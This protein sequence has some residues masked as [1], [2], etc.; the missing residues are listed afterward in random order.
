[1]DTFSYS[2]TYGSSAKTKCRVLSTNFGDGYRQRAADGI[3]AA[4]VSWSLSFQHLDSEDVEDI[5]SF[6]DE[7]GGH[8]AFQWTPPGG[9]TALKWTCSE[10]DHTPEPGGRGSISATFIQEF[11]L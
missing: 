9:T 11:D 2:P 7:K 8:E 10:W 1:M 3:N 4:P 6:F 5:L